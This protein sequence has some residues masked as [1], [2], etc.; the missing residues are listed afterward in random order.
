M[1]NIIR[2]VVIALTNQYIARVYISYVREN[3]F[4]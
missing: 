2:Y 1:N 4:S 3:R